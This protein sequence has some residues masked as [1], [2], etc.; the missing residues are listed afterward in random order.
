MYSTW[1]NL[2][3][4]TL[5]YWNLSNKVIP[6]FILNHILKF[7]LALSIMSNNKRSILRT[8]QHIPALGLTKAAI[9]ISLGIFIIWVNLNTKVILGINKLYKKW[10]SIY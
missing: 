9:F 8:V 5:L 4:I 6:S 3:K 10:E 1:V 7:F 2:N